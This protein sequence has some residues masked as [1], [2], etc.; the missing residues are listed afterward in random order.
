M[1]VRILTIYVLFAFLSMSFSQ[2]IVA[3]VKKLEYS[4]VKLMN[5]KGAEEEKEEG[6]TEKNELDEDE[7]YIFNEPESI[8]FKI[9]ASKKH[10]PV[11]F[12]LI[13]SSYSNIFTP[14]PLQA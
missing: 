2:S 5:V 9:N 6:D 8:V 7:V 13:C 3:L 4:D 14:P 12:T 11:S 1:K 10:Y